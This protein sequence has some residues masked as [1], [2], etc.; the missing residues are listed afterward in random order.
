MATLSD[1]KAQ[2][3]ADGVIEDAEVELLRKQVYADGSVEKAEAE[4]LAELRDEARAGVGQG[5]NADGLGASERGEYP[6]RALQW[7]RADLAVRTG[8]RGSLFPWVRADAL[9]ALREWQGAA[10]LAG[11]READGLAKLPEEE[12]AE[13][14]KLWD[15]VAAAVKEP[16]APK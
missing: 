3:L 16:D 2:I 13:W 12:Q 14:K 15:D 7:L 5:R 8:Q 9:K 1:L 6:R 10:D 4:F 11:V